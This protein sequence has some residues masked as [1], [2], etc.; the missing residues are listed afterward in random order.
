MKPTVWRLTLAA[1]LISVSSGV[2][3]GA[4]ETLFTVVQP[5][6]STEGIQTAIVT[7]SSYFTERPLGLCVSF[8][9]ADSRIMDQLAHP[10]SRS[11]AFLTGAKAWPERSL[12]GDTLRVF[13][14]LR[15]FQVDRSVVCCPDSEIV[16]SIYDCLLVNAFNSRKQL[17]SEH[18]VWRAAQFVDVRILGSDYKYLGGVIAC[19]EIA[20]HPFAR[21]PW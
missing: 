19:S 15:Q 12:A 14:D 4:F 17:D 5:M 18:R 1:T 13:L 8:L 2:T 9:G 10:V 11:P 20:K 16:R 7:Y 6:T 3:Q 21:E